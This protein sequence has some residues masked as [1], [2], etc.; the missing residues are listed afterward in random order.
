[1]LSAGSEYA[2]SHH[3]PQRIKELKRGGVDN[4]D[5]GAKLSPG[6]DRTSA[7]CGPNRRR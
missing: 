1:M 6:Y 7:L 4:R 2:L 5:D 3:T